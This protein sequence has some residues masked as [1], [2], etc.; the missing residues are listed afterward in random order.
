M[1]LPVRI[2]LEILRSLN[3]LYLPNMKP[4]YQ[5]KPKL[6]TF[7]RRVY[8]GLLDILRIM[9]NDCYF[10][11]HRAVENNSKPTAGE[12]METPVRLQVAADPDA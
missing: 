9:E 10:I 4:V 11:V 6:P 3:N 12:G 1:A 5:L 7:H 2:L 8:A